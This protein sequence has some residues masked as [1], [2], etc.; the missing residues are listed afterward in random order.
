MHCMEVAYP[1]NCTTDENPAGIPYVFFMI[2]DGLPAGSTTQ[3]DFLLEMAPGGRLGNQELHGDAIMGTLKE[4][5][6]I[7]C[8][9]TESAIGRLHFMGCSRV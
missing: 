7:V 6:A 1:G 3:L 5:N 9:S 4:G 8:G 2:Q